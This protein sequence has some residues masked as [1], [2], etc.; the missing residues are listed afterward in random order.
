VT[1]ALAA[2]TTRRLGTEAKVVAIRPVLYSELNVSTPSTATAR[3][4]Y[5]R[6]SRP[7]SSGSKAGP[8]VGALDRANATRAP[9]AIGVATATRRVQ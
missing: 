9:A 3:M 5:S 7:G 1:A 8:V 4:A 2:R 6:L